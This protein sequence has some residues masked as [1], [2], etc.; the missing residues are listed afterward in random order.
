MKK[1]ALLAAVITLSACFDTAVAQSTGWAPRMNSTVM[2]EN[3]DLNFE[4]YGTYPGKRDAP[5]ATHGF[6]SNESAVFWLV[7][8]WEGPR[9][10]V[11]RNAYLALGDGEVSEAEVNSLGRTYMVRVFVDGVL[12]GEDRFEEILGPE[13]WGPA[14][15]PSWVKPLSTARSVKVDFLNSEEEVVLVRTFNMVRARSSAATLE[16]MQ[17]RCP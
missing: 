13:D 3:R 2:C 16:N 15:N 14:D 8:S 9:E 1:V 17:W 4:L 11:L 5:D 12:I 10:P 7:L 6:R